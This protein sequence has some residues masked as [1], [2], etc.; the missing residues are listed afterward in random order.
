M[1]MRAKRKEI[2]GPDAYA[3]AADFERIFIHGMNGLYLLSFLLTADGDKA[4]EC[5]VAA[6]GESTQG[7]PVFK[8]WARSWARRTIIQCAIRLIAPRQQSQ[9]AQRTNTAL[10]LDRLPAVLQAEVSAIL[11]LAPFERFALVMSTLEGYSDQDCSILMN[12]TRKDVSEARFR[13]LKELGKDVKRQ[14]T[15]IDTTPEKLNRRE[16]RAAVID[17]GIAKYFGM[18]ARGSSSSEI[19]PLGP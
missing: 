4:E 3:T 10:T 13:A 14:R 6:I 11:D 2:V 7:N 8:E 16:D 1:I 17:L 9:A 12:C 5:F 18:P 15:S 19:A